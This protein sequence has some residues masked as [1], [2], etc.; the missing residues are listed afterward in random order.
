[1]NEGLG[2]RRPDDLSSSSSPV[3][4]LQGTVAVPDG[5]IACIAGNM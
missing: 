3:I 4:S 1:M 2:A 5:Q